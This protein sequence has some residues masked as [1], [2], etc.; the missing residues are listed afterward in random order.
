MT[1]PLISG[2]AVMMAIWT[3]CLSP[4]VT[5][6]VGTPV[7]D[8]ESYAVYRALIPAEGPA[9]VVKATRIIL[10]QETVT[11]W[12]CIPQGRPLQEEWKLVWDD[13]ARQNSTSRTLEQGFDLGIP[14]LLLPSASIERA[15]KDWTGFYALYPGS[16]GFIDVSAVG[17]DP[18]KTRAIAYVAHYCGGL[19]GG[20]THHLMEKRGG[21]W[22]H[23][24]I[25]D[26]QNCTWI[27]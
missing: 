8:S 9:G 18:D 17:F 27:A 11:N 13:F 25:K 22:S 19:C 1:S 2:S 4:G 16:G 6:Q 20:G 12:T 26:V 24:S 5:E 23:A 14:Y 21:Q 3:A 7:S 10:R 15:F